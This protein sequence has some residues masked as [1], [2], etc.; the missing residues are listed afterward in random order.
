MTKQNLVDVATNSIITMIQNKEYDDDGYLPSEG[1]LAIKLEVSRSTI[2]EAVRSLEV[3]GFVIR[4][5]GKGVQVS[6][7][8]VGVMTRSLS[9][10][11]LK[12]D[13]ILDE[14]LEIRIVLE[15]AC[16]FLASSFATKEHLKELTQ[17]IGIMESDDIDDD[18]YYDADL[19]FHVIIAKASG[20]RIHQAII[21]AYTPILRELIISSSPANCRLEKEFH[22]HRNVLEAI[23][24]R[25]GKLAQEHMAIHLQATNDNR[26]KSLNSK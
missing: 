6:D 25:D 17:L 19:K 13:V 22:Y 1:D 26:K 12:D 9:D 5:H 18:A 23:K 14:L 16:A 2:R 8:S 7:N 21:T 4:K 20:N 3:R 10:M 15:P 24:N 11:L